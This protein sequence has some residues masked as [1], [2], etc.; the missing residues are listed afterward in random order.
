MIYK[1]ASDRNMVL[2]NQGY[3]TSLSV[4]GQIDVHYKIYQPIPSVNWAS[5]L[6]SPDL[7]RWTQ[8]EYYYTLS[9]HKGLPLFLVVSGKKL[10]NNN[11]FFKIN[12]I[13]K[14]HANYIQV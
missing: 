13:Y 9:G 4:G 8:N 10:T 14:L 1:H 12:K 6:Y 11:T 2:T 5:A 3:H 7:W